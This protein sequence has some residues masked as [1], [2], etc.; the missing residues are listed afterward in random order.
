M[1]VCGIEIIKQT[2]AKEAKAKSSSQFFWLLIIIPVHACTDNLVLK[3]TQPL[4]H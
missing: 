1:E 2:K 4:L 3:H